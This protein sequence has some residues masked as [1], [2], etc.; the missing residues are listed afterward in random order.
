M[1]RRLSI[2]NLYLAAGLFLFLT[3][4][5]LSA[6]HEPIAVH[7]HSVAQEAPITPA[8]REWRYKPT[9]LDGQPIEVIATITINF[10][11]EG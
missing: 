10:R 9:L 7:F 4:P 2:L 3:A 6:Q 1:P 8:V 11:L 5:P